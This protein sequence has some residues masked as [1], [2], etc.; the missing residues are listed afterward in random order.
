MIGI[1][2]SVEDVVEGG[3]SDFGTTHSLSLLELDV[4]YTSSDVMGESTYRV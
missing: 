2:R 1:Q 3:E 4:L